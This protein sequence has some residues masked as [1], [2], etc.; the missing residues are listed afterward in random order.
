MKMGMDGGDSLIRVVAKS[1]FLIQQKTKLKVLHSLSSTEVIGNDRW[2]SF[3]PHDSLLP[4]N[5]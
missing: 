4:V 3:F 5:R 2:A 1:K